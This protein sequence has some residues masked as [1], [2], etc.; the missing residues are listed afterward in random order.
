MRL[1]KVALF[2]VFIWLLPLAVQAADIQ[3]SVQEKVSFNLR[4]ILS[5][6]P[7]QGIRTKSNPRLSFRSIREDL[8]GRLQ[9]YLQ[10][11][12]MTLQKIQELENY[13]SV[14]VTNAEHGLVQA[15]VTP[16]DVETISNLPFIKKINLPD[17]AVTR[18]GSVV[19]E[20][21]ALLQT[22]ALRELGY[23]GAGIKIGVISDG[24]EG[25]ETAQ[26]TLDLPDVGVVTYPGTGSEGTAMLEI[27]HDLAH[28][29]QLGFC[30]PE[31]S[32]EFIQCV[33]DLKNV[34]GAQII[35]D[36]LGFYQEPFFEDGAVAKAVQQAVQEGILYVSSAGND[37]QKHYAA[38]Y[39]G[40][41]W[42][43]FAGSVHDF[44]MAVGQASDSVI[45]VVAPPKT[46]IAAVLQWD[47]P[48]GQ[49]GSDY[50]LFMVDSSGTTVDGF[51]KNKQNGDDD[52]LEY[53]FVTNPF[54]AFGIAYF[55]VSKVTGQDRK[56]K[57][58]FVRADSIQDYP[59]AEN[60]IFGHPAIPGVLAIGAI[61]ANDPGLDEIEPFSSH[62]PAQV[63]FPS[64]ET[65][66][67]PDLCG[68]DNV[69]VTGAGGFPTRFP[70]TS[71]SAPHI[72]G[73]AALLM[74]K[75]SNSQELA[76]R[77]TT[78]AI[79]LG[80]A[81]SDPAFGAG[82]VNV[83]AASGETPPSIATPV[84]VPSDSDPPESPASESQPEESA[85]FNPSEAS[86]TT[87]FETDTAEEEGGEDEENDATTGQAPAAGGCS[88]MES[89]EV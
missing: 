45:E 11:S 74:S 6:L 59:V 47:E 9:V 88:L 5:D 60:S 62:G 18:T 51:S 54:D 82:L 33:Q 64:Q 24:I 40:I 35:V 79:D 3:P 10:V 89:S 36:D 2:P 68:I 58:Y 25:L 37:A 87:P 43:G 30:G 69:S 44:G 17:Y 16:N 73:I 26:A 67:K 53:I 75:F 84:P 66:Q 38:D 63:L 21:D 42:P 4:S 14:D 80:P 13:A 55:M 32:I 8:K 50:D 85:S 19:T 49:A 76:E 83:F 86:P 20:G 46:T 22:S 28:S 70:G 61:S 65:R 27:I 39:R 12:E 23:N 52:P 78:T 41:S 15:W 71:A 34:F 72:A 1:K 31:T 29:A 81:G 56:I 48:F 7:R 77:L 57:L